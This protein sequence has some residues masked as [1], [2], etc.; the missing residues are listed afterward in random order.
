MHTS[1]QTEV[2]ATRNTFNQINQ[3]KTPIHVFDY[4]SGVSLSIYIVFVQIEKEMNIPSQ[5][6]DDVITASHCTSQKFTS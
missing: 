2:N 6:L 4:N 5:S 3:K 1:I